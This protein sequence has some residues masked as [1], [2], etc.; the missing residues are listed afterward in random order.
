MMAMKKFMMILA[1]A[2]MMIWSCVKP[3]IDT[4][5]T[6][7]INPEDVVF[8]AVTEA[9][10]AAPAA[11]GVVSWT[12]EDEIGVYDGTNYVKATVLSAD[13]NKITFSASVNASASKYIAVSPYE[14]ALTD[15]GAFTSVDGKVK[16][17]TSAVQT[18]GKQ[19]ISIASVSSAAES[20][21]FRNVG[22]LLRFKVNKAAVKK[23]KITG[24][25]GEKIAGA[26]SVDPATG[27]ATGELSATEIVVDVTPGV[28][29]FIALAPGVSLPKGFVITLYGSEMNEA[30]YEGEVASAGALTLGR[31]QMINLGLIDGWI[32]NYK[33]WQAG[34]PITIAGVEYTKEST[35]FSGTLL[36]AKDADFDTFDALY[37]KA[38]AFFLEQS[39][40][41]KFIASKFINLGTAAAPKDVLL[42]ARY[43][44]A[45][46]DFHPTRYFC[47]LNGN[48]MARNVKFDIS[49]I[50]DQNMFQGY[51]SVAFGNIHFDNCKFV[52]PVHSGT[53]SKR[54][55]YLNTTSNQDIKPFTS[56]RVVNSKIQSTFNGKLQLI[57]A[58]NLFKYL[59]GIKEITFQNNV[60]YNE[61]SAGSISLFTSGTATS[62]A[63]STTTALKIEN[64]TFYNM[65]GGSQYFIGY[66]LGSLSVKNN[67]MCSASDTKSYFVQTTET[68][69]AYPYLFENNMTNFPIQHFNV[70]QPGVYA[71]NSPTIDKTFVKEVAD[72]T[73]AT[74]FSKVDIEKGIFIPAEAYASYGAKQ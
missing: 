74:M 59:D 28:D 58:S 37:G 65:L 48:F 32:D 55:I 57:Y 33:L 2:Q 11:G 50:S 42:I 63:E 47:L 61:N 34:K 19:V 39:A 60:F 9:T 69:K 56:L 73:S 49:G 15:N 1:M 5:V 24:A 7:N 35:G 3:E 54:F 51:T 52:I 17:A 53:N 21:V 30:G 12:M 43:D 71:K 8:T 26:V 62:D 45:P 27:V 22:N 13:G 64:N 4:P 66:T 6:E 38:G 41:K 10:K 18:A 40:G 70:N 46:V 23:V 16:I 67:L 14:A 25:N 36:S 72:A 68:T 44:N 31:N 29:N 20:F